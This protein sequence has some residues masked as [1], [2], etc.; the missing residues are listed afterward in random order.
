MPR[1]IDDFVPA[2]GLRNPHAQTVFGNFLRGPRRAWRRER[3]E[4]PDG[5]FLDLDWH[6][7]ATGAPTVLL[8][9]GLEGSS[10]SSYVLETARLVAGLGWSAVALNYRSCSGEPNRLAKSY[11]SGFIDDALFVA[12]RLPRPRFAVG[13][14]LGGSILLNLLAQRGDQAGLAA[15]VA[16]GTPYDLA[17]CAACIDSGRGMAVVYQQRFLRT[18]KAKALV[19][20]A[21]FP[22]SLDARRIRAARSL[23]DFDD[24]V[25][26]PLHGFADAADYYARCST[27]GQVERIEVPTLLI[28]AEDDPIAPARTLPERVEASR[29]L[30][31][32]RARHGGHVGF[33]AGRPWA[34]R[35]WAEEKAVA[36][37]TERSRSRSR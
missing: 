2:K 14:S 7:G 27:A 18:L 32:L 16:I 30:H 3:V 5:D 22:G 1:L 15:A 36:W 19:K 31:V 9:H 37:L 33:A 34:P 23:R 17:A 12:Q 28:S 24:C 21:R 13:Y 25:T 4:T 20:A 6:D 8:L 10:D 26:A 35:W 11:N 29:H